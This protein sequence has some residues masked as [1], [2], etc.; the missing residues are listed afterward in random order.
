MEGACWCRSGAASPPVTACTLPS[1]SIITGAAKKSSPES[2]RATSV[3]ATLLAGDR[4]RSDLGGRRPVA[5]RRWSALRSGD[6]LDGQ[7]RVAAERQVDDAADRKIDG[8]AGGDLE[9]E[10]V[11]DR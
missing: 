6:P 1:P 8:A 7:R 10:C 11:I 4:P 3:L 5:A 2:M 9:E